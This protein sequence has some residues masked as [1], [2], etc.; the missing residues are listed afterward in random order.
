MLVTG[1]GIAGVEMRAAVRAQPVDAVQVDAWGAEILD[2][3]RVLLLVAEGGEIECDVVIDELAEVGEPGW[4]VGVVALR[5]AG[6]GI[7]HGI[8]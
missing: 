4:D 1:R 7:E 2:A 6:I 8:G 5:V 3:Q